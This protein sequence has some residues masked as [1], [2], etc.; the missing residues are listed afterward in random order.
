MGAIRLPVNVDTARD[1]ESLVKLRGYVDAVGGKAILC[2]FP[3]DFAAACG[4]DANACNEHDTSG[5]VDNMAEA[6]A[7]WASVHSVFS[8]YSDVRYE[9]LNEPFGYSL[10]QA[11]A[12]EYLAVM[13]QIILD[14]ELPEWKCIIAA[15]WYSSQPHPLALGW[16]GDIAY[17]AY[18]NWL[19]SGSTREQFHQKI[20]SD[21]RDL[22][23]RIW[24]TEFGANLN[25]ATS[26][27]ANF[28]LGLQDALIQLKS[29]G[30]PVKGA[31]LWHGWHNGDTYDFW[32]PSNANGAKLVQ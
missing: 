14:A 9:L 17:H 28:L 5:R 3:T 8:E 16:L 1:R 21:I 2:M 30:T 7:A 12:A 11:G 6:S 31:F 20:Y 24:I 27:D 4:A 29:D 32:E 22:S 25:L 18:P 13:R 19:P 10:D 15:L 23:S 26:D